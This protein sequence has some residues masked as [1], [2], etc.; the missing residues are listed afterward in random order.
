MTVRALLSLG[1]SA[2]GL[3]L[4]RERCVACDGEI[5]W[6]SLFC[7]SCA[8]C[9]VRA[10]DAGALAPFVYGGPLAQAITR[11]KYDKRPE[12]GGRLAHLLLRHLEGSMASFDVVVPVPLHAARLAERG[13]NQSALLAQPIA[14]RLGVPCRARALARSRA[15][16]QQARLDRPQR[17]ENVA[18]AFVLREPARVRGG[19]VLL[20][21]DVC[22]TGATLHACARALLDGG[23]REVTMMALALAE[24]RHDAS[25]YKSSP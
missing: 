20:V 1:H 16:A 9:L 13:Y 22:T 17:R 10:N 3:L 24:L 19:H 25:C 4:S 7:P 15:T 12:L 23:A 14:T 6:R 8:R 2:L 21:D 18:G 5:R 11:L